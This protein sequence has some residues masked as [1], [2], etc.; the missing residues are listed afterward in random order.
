[1]SKGLAPRRQIG[2]APRLGGPRVAADQHPREVGPVSRRGQRPSPASYRSA[3]ASS[4]ILC[5]P[6]LRRAWRLAVPRG[7]PLPEG[8]GLT[9]FL[10]W[11][12]AGSV[13]PLDRW[14]VVSAGGT[15]SPRTWP[16][17]LWPELISILSST[18]LTVFPPA[19]QLG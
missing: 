6:P 10:V 4:L 5:P 18:T 9:P 13:V 16:P 11:T 15:L 19:L 1:T 12:G 3:F 2:F 14:H 8:D 7:R 17:A